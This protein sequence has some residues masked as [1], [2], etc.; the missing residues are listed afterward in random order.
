M[1][2]FNEDVKF[3]RERLK[4]A[5]NREKVKQTNAKKQYDYINK[6]EKE[7]IETGCSVQ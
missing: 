4:D 5:E 2:R 6:L 7:L 1:L 3:L